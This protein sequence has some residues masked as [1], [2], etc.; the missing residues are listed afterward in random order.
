MLKLIMIFYHLLNILSVPCK[1]LRHFHEDISGYALLHPKQ[2]LLNLH[3]SEFLK[4]A[5]L[6]SIQLY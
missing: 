1:A 5:M 3:K 4:S 2:L 6:C